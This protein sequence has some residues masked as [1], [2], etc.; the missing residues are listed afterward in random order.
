MTSINANNNTT[1]QALFQSNASTNRLETLFINTTTPTTGRN[2]SCPTVGD[3]HGIPISPEL[4]IG[5][6]ILALVLVCG[7]I[8]VTHVRGARHW[9]QVTPHYTQY[10]TA[11][12]RRLQRYQTIELGL[13]TQCIIPHDTVC[14]EIIRHGVVGETTNNTC[15]NDSVTAHGASETSPQHANAWECSICM[16]EMIVGVLVSFSMNPHCNHVFHHVCIKEWLQTSHYCPMC[17]E[18]LLPMEETSKCSRDTTL[19]YIDSSQPLMQCYV[20]MTHK[21]VVLPTNWETLVSDASMLRSIQERV[22]WVPTQQQLQALRGKSFMAP[23]NDVE[24]GS[25]PPSEEDER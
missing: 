14:D 8:V 23:N 20:C 21:M 17:R 24:V 18:R 1:V 7:I 6:A 11:K 5:I 12:D 15:G 3:R 9:R 19:T 4:G 22:S 2:F 13:V 25:F 16:E 10:P